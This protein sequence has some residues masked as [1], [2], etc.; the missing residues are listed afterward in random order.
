MRLVHGNTELT[1]IVYNCQALMLICRLQ[2]A[3]KKD[4]TS[5]TCQQ[6]KHEQSVKT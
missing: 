2:R 1:S 5:F 4:E 3:A 6:E